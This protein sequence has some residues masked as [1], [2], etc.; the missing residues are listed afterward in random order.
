MSKLRSTLLGLTFTST[1]ALA[2]ANAADV[3]RAGGS[4]MDGPAYVSVTNWS[5]PYAGVNLGYGWTSDDGALSP[6][7]FFGGGQVGYNWQGVLP[8]LGLGNHLVLGVEADLQ[9]ADISD[10][11][12]GVTSRVNS[13]GTIRG[14]AGYAFDRTLVYFTGGFAFGDVENS[15]LGS[16]TQ[17]GYA[18]GGGIEYK[19]NPSWSVKGEYQFVSLD[20]SDALGAGP[21]GLTDSD[22]SEF[23]TLRVGLNYHFGS[24]YDY[25]K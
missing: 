17:T 5:G 11:A 13:F 4:T 22:R 21:L 1:L 23:H 24:S 2:S 10:S 14:R 15:F 6:S 12:F 3:Y 9:G 20:A 7:G 8:S 19:F 16:E 25:L 18:L